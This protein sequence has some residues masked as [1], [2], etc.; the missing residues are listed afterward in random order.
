VTLSNTLLIYLP[1]KAPIDSTIRR[2]LY[3][4]IGPSD[5]ASGEATDQALP[6]G[7]TVPVTWLT[8]VTTW[9]AADAPNWFSYDLLILEVPS[10]EGAEDLLRYR[11]ELEEALASSTIIWILTGASDPS[12]ATS[13]CQ[14]EVIRP[15][16]P[17]VPATEGPLSTYVA[18]VPSLG[19]V[20]RPP[21]GARPVAP[22]GS[23]KQW[24]GGFVRDDGPV[25][26]TLPQSARSPREAATMLQATVAPRRRPPR[27]S[28]D[29]QA[30]YVLTALVLAMIG[31]VIWL[32]YAQ[33]EFNQRYAVVGDVFTT[34][35]LGLAE[36]NDPVGMLVEGEAKRTLAL[37]AKPGDVT[38]SEDIALLY[39]LGLFTQGNRAM[40]AW[41]KSPERQGRCE[42]G[43]EDALKASAERSLK[44]G[45][46]PQA[47]MLSQMHLNLVNRL[48]CDSSPMDLSRSQAVI[49]LTRANHIAGRSRK[50][51]FALV[52]PGPYDQ[53]VPLPKPSDVD[54]T[55]LD[56]LA[57]AAI[58][59]EMAATDISPDRAGQMWQDFVIRHPTSERV[60]EALF[61]SLIAKMRSHEWSARNSERAW[62][63]ANRETL[64]IVDHFLSKY[65]T[66]YLADDAALLGLRVSAVLRQRVDAERYLGVLMTAKRPD[67]MRELETRLRTRMH[68]LVAG[69]PAAPAAAF[70][71]NP[72]VLSNGVDVAALGTTA[73]H[74]ALR[75]GLRVI[76]A[77]VPVKGRH[78][79]D[80]ALDVM[81]KVF[82][83]AYSPVQQS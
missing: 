28:S 11:I 77:M 41:F 54:P 7:A 30:I 64:P 78:A 36:D 46:V 52:A 49:D 16:Q 37:A 51:A 10:V 14:T 33:R 21:V 22:I 81:M 29:R 80:I 32:R 58:V 17:I 3:V 69:L 43:V 1:W 48:G 23:S 2:C 56:N 55:L 53:V 40:D 15:R 31:A 18:S 60:D 61:N 5:E 4:A 20:V 42:Q 74:G 82:A 68:P 38:N 19:L 34:T 35:Y 71:V 26:A 50:W 24:A 45:N 44:A 72:S 59:R 62:V 57:Y 25:K 13:L 66:S 9:A 65:P 12:I 83:E 27:P 76:S 79:K 70:C 63:Q 39:S 67:T 47:R 8:D 75:D 73:E 6:R